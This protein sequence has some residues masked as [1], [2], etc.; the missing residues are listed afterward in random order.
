M[1]STFF[2][3]YLSGLAEFWSNVL[4]IRIP[5][6]LI[7]ILLAWWLFGKGKRGPWCRVRW[8]C[9]C[10]GSCGCTCGRCCCRRGEHEAHEHGGDEHDEDE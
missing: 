3:W 4:T 6:I 7:L 1:I 10:D 9:C 5:H 2:D 8:T